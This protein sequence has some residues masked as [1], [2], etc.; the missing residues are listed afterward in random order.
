MNHTTGEAVKHIRIKP[1]LDIPTLAIVL[2]IS[3]LHLFDIENDRCE[4]SF[5]V[6]RRLLAFAGTTMEEFAE[7]LSEKEL[8][9]TD[10]APLKYWQKNKKR[11]PLK[12]F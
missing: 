1:G 11:K 2:N 3:S 4:L 10:F 5:L 7:T 8:G 12:N 9:R 6:A